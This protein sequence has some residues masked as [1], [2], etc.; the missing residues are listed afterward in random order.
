MNEKNV[1]RRSWVSVLI[2]VGL[3]IVFLVLVDIGA[4][5]DELKNADWGYLALAVSF[6]LAGFFIQAIRWRYLLRNLP[7]LPYTFHTLNI[8]T[9]TNLMTFIPSIPTRVFLMGENE[10]VTIP[11]ATSSITIAFILDLVMKI[12]AIM[13]LILLRSDPSS[14]G[15]TIFLYLIIV[16]VIFAGIIL[17][18]TNIDKIA[19][20]FTP[21]LGRLSFLKDEQAERLMSGL[22]EGLSEVGSTRQLSIALAYSLSAWICFVVFFVIGLLAFNIEQPLGDLIMAVIAA[23][24]FINPTGPYLPGIFNVLLVAPMTLVSEID[25]EALFAFSLVIYA[26]LL[27]VWVGLGAW[28]LRYFNIRLSDLRQ[29]VSEGIEQ[30][31]ST[32]N[33]AE[34]IPSET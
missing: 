1:K 12:L 29:W 13:G 27:V 4:V 26:L 6:L 17:L 8:A 9:M 28:G 25:V 2:V 7:R 16:I 31:S 15:M 21:L 19:T 22:A 30:L 20:R 34:Q 32:D 14:T 10:K 11:Q 3:I 24:I 23:I 33:A 5:I 18:A